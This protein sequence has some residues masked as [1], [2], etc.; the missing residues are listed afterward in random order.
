MTHAVSRHA[1]LTSLALA[2]AAPAAFAQATPDTFDPIVVT[3]SRYPQHLS[4]VLSDTQTISSEDIARSGASS[5]VD[6]LQ[7]QR[8]IE[9]A[10]NGGAGT[11]ASVFIRGANSNQNIVLV[12]GVR[13][14]SST[15][16]T[17]NWSALPLSSIDHIEI[18]YGPLSTMYGADAIGGVIQIFTKK[19]DGATRVS[20]FAGYGSNNTRQVEAQVAGSTAGPNSFSYALAAG[21]EKSDG[22]SASKLGASPEYTYN[23]DKD[24]Y[25]KESFSG[26]FGYQMAK[27]HEVGLT[28]LNSELKAQYDAGPGYD[29]R[30]NEKLENISVFT[31]NEFLPNWTSELRYAEARDKAGNDGGTDSWS[32]SQINTKQ[33]DLTWQ[34]DIRFGR[35]NLQLLASYR[36]EDVTSTLNKEVTGGRNTKSFAASYNLVRG[37]HLVSISG[38]RDDSS[39]FGTHNTG[40]VAYGYRITNALRANA[41]YGT[42]FRAPTFNELYY[43]G[44]GLATNKPEQGRNA[45]VGLRY[46]DGVSKL[47]ASYYH[48]KVSDLLVNTSP[49]PDPLFTGY[50]CAYNVNKALLEGLTIAGARKFGAFNVS[51]NIDLQDPR[52][53]TKDKQLVRRA[54]QHANFAVDYTAGALTS[55]AEWQLSGKRFDD[56][57]NKNVLGGYGL[58][59]LYATYQFTRDWSVLARWNNIANK[60]YEL[61]RFYA[62]PGSKVFVGV[63]YGMK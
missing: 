8:G 21:K 45:E 52:D 29:A 3:A 14:G 41:S 36:D 1:A 48:N 42:S 6:L 56:A 16:G 32:K 30:S 60:D 35:D 46:D 27:G 49:C 62:T 10:R 44:Y 40:S 63:R 34:N 54:K 26:Q 55:G 22:F 24:G 43:P 50:G 39:A 58:V 23:P 53:E 11:A 18:V 37:A 31:K 5:I 13:I 47:S 59:N 28:F 38:R 20:A 9:V 19:G 15:L 12:D 7:K 61:A 51:G 4:E 33:T 25:D 2:I 57:A 17:A